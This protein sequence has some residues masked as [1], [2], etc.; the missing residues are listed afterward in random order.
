MYDLL[1]TQAT[2]IDGTGGKPYTADLGVI[3]DQIVKIGAIKGRQEAKKIYPVTGLVLTP[4]FVD[5]HGHSDYSLLIDHRAES[6]I[7]QGITTEIVGNCGYSAAPIDEPL[8]S[9]RKKEYE[10]IYGLC[11]KWRTFSEYLQKVKNS[12]P[13]LNY[14]FLVGYNT[15]RASA[16]GFANRYPSQD[17]TAK[18][19]FLVK[20][21]LE[22]GAFGLSVGLAYAPAC[23]AHKEE[24]IHLAHLTAQRG[25]VL[26]S[27][28]RNEGNSLLQ[29][30]E[31]ILFIASSANIPLQISH[32]KT[33]GKANWRKLPH[34]FDM[35][36]TAREKELEVTLDR[37]PYLASQTSLQ[38]LLPLC[39]QEGGPE[40]II[41]RL[42]NS[43]TRK[44]I[45]NQLKI[46]H[47]EENFWHT[48]SI[49]LTAGEKSKDFQG[50]TIFELADLKKKKPVEAALD[51]L[52]QE[53]TQVEIIHFCMSEENLTSILQ[54][55]YT[56]IGSDSSSR[57]IKGP[58]RI[59]NPHPRAFGTF[60][61]VIQTFSSEKQILPLPEIIK[62]MTSLPA[63]KFG[64]KKRGLIKEGM[65]AD[66]VL[67]DP[68]KITAT[69]TY[70]NPFQY[71]SGIHLVIINGKVCIEE[72]H[73]RQ[74]GQGKILYKK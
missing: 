20:E 50:L 28:I 13:S 62:K 74:S 51:L 64:L 41:Q 26:T 42:E 56:M 1:I 22:C 45:I 25:G 61:K 46:D 23:F 69:A 11:L 65:Y 14:A 72:G 71:P 33:E 9:E 55:P 43:S 57:S 54:C 34:A 32:F 49:S 4:G 15:I 48:V 37:Y 30:L 53:K 44:S 52:V 68:Q 2:I 27:H 40:C 6:K 73:Y 47:P 17:E 66:L 58:L 39:A 3:D 36:E 38:A 7:R 35:I 18:M 63:K 5:I 19:E 67:F 8:L 24:I 60:P 31:E 70:Q 10:T 12:S 21:A 29:A 16:M 59:G